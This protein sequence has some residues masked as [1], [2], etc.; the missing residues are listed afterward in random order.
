[1]LTHKKT[2]FLI[3]NIFD[4][5]KIIDKIYYDNSKK[6]TNDTKRNQCPYCLRQFGRTDAFRNHAKICRTKMEQLLKQYENNPS[7]FKRFVIDSERDIILELAFPLAN[8]ER[9]CMLISGMNGCGKSTF[10]RK[11]LANYLMVYKTEMFI[12]FHHKKQI[13]N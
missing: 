7:H 12:Y 10:I 2:D 11:L 3:A 1:M 8:N 5:D 9:L 13:I 4:G 6:I